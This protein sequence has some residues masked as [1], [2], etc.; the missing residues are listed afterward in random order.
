MGAIAIYILGYDVVYLQRYRLLA[1]DVSGSVKLL[2]VAA[3]AP[4]VVAAPNTTYCLGGYAPPVVGAALTCLFLDESDVVYPPVENAAMFVTTRIKATPEAL[5]YN[6]TGPPVPC[7]Q[8]DPLCTYETWPPGAEQLVYVGGPVELAT[9][10]IQHAVYAA[11]IA[12]Y[13]WSSFDMEGRI[14]GELLRA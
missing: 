7:S 3:Q 11:T 4:Y 12:P 10:S 14:V 2:L 6:K 8:T 9:L 5:Q 13:A 1:T